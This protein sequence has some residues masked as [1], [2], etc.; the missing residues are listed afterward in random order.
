MV[1]AFPAVG[2]AAEAPAF[3]AGEDIED[4]AELPMAPEPGAPAGDLDE[5]QDA[6]RVSGMWGSSER[7]VFSPAGLYCMPSRWM[8]AR[9][10]ARPQPPPPILPLASS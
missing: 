5:G 1:P 4:A 8:L 2:Y 9:L 7:G 3:P 6:V 10:P